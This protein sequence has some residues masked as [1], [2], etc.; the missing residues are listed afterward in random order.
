MEEVHVRVYA[1]AVVWYDGM[2]ASENNVTTNVANDKNQ[3]M[4]CDYK[5]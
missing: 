1:T 2:K 3:M 4:K 5:R